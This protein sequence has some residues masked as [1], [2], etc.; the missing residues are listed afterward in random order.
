MGGNAGLARLLEARVPDDWPPETL[1]DALPW[2][3]ARL[4]S[5]PEQAGW[6]GW[7]A[8]AADA[9]ASPEPAAQ[10]G[11]CAGRGRV[12]VGSGGF[13][14]PPVDGAV[15]I[16]YSVL[17]EFQGQGYATEIVRG[18]VGWALS[19][20]G[21]SRVT[22]ETEWAN[23]AS[24]QVLRKAGF[25]PF[26]EAAA[27]GGAH[28]SIARDSTLEASGELLAGRAVRPSD[29]ETATRFAR[30][31]DEEDYAGAA[32]CLAA[33]CEYEIGGTIHVGP[34]AIIASYRGNG[35]WAAQTLDS[36]RYESRVREGSGVVVVEFVDRLEHGGL[37][38]THR[39][40]QHLE[41][42][43]A[44]LVVAIRHVDLPGEQD[45]L[46]RF[47]ERAGVVR[48]AADDDRGA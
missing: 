25:Q 40:E 36:L 14:G 16:G 17:P 32:E 8:L 39:C 7:Y 30:S 19:Q 28:F 9:P 13:R 23:P 2:F 15:E 38:H 44:G 47:F 10:P 35:E 34:D 48:P 24:A 18:L 6:W 5:Q 26:G 1:A 4:E 22:A 27:S 42:D 41:L 37:S 46:E 33:N 21:V 29:V 20:A 43:G 12:L 11:S 31:L 45:S 3:L